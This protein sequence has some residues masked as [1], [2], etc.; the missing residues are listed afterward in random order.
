MYE[1]NLPS[2]LMLLKHKKAIVIHLCRQI[3]SWLRIVLVPSI[4]FRLRQRQ[5]KYWGFQDTSAS[6]PHLIE[7]EWFFIWPCWEFGLTIF[8]CALR[9]FSFP[10][11]QF[12]KL[13]QFLQQGQELKFQT[14]NLFTDLLR[15][16][17]VRFWPSVFC[18]YKLLRFPSVHKFYDH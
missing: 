9:H 16:L 2:H 8:L 1:P 10:F 18:E 7:R 4:S 13:S 6:N 3:L 12:N 5:M 11:E 14:S 17:R 15:L